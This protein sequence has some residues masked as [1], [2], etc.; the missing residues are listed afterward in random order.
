MRIVIGYFA[1]P[2]IGAISTSVANA[3]FT[4]P[5]KYCYTPEDHP[6]RA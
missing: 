4:R 3:G 2:A 6:Q 5:R 1:A